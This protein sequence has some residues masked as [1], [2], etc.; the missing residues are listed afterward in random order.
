MVVASTLASLRVLVVLAL[1]SLASHRMKSLIVGGIMFFGTLLLIVGLSLLDSVETS[2]QRSLTGSITGHLQVYS[3]DARDEL[4]IF[5]SGTMGGDDIG[6]IVEFSKVKEVIEGIDGV[7]AVVPMGPVMATVVGGNDFDRALAE[8]GEALERGDEAAITAS[9]T[10][11]RKLSE[12]M[13]RGFR[14]ELEISSNTAELEAR[15]ARLESLQ[16]DAFWTAFRADPAAQ[17]RFLETKIAPLAAD[18]RM[19]ILRT[20]GT[21]LPLFGE[22]FDRFEIVEGEAVPPGERGLLINKRLHERWLKHLVARTLDRVKEARDEGRLIADDPDLQSRVALMTRQYQQILFQ[23]SPAA[24]AS[25]EAE[26]RK[27]LPQTEGDLEALVR[28]FLEVDDD[29]FEQRFAFFYAHI[30]PHIQLY[31]FNVGDTVTLRAVTKTGYFKA[32]NIKIYGRF[33]FRGL[34]GSDLSG[35]FNLMDLMT[36]RDLYGLMTDAQRA[37]LESIRQDVGVVEVSRE[38]AEDAL[39]GG[40]ADEPLVQDAVP[41]SSGFDAVDH[42]ELA[43]GTAPDPSAL[44]FTQH[45]I[46]HGLALHAAIVLDDP[47]QIDEAR[48]AI[49]AAIE[50]HGLGLT[51]VDWQAASGMVGQFVIVIRVVLYVAIVIIFLVALVIINNSMV[52]ATM[53]RIGEI[54]TLRAI[55]AQ[56]RFVLSM[57]LIETVTLGLL[58]GTLGALAASGLLV[59]LGHSGIPSGG[60]EVLIFLFSGQRLFPTLEMAHV[61]L[62]IFVIVMVSLV[63]TLYPALIA[64]RVQ[65]VVA[66]AGSGE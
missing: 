42:L 46:D 15:I 53:D 38:D 12:F 52:M 63:A 17:M 48:A 3:S 57:F 10:Q 18:G 34:E 41:G 6:E 56:R 2:M 21:D 19:I 33:S 23:L 35:A 49:E 60:N 27:L 14:N 61:A 59:W 16:D 45:D 20:I 44:R 54:G 28:A 39:F 43:L 4:A 29:N 37:E 32:V 5:G 51:V 11:L 31:P 40:G 47:E 65:P 58:A 24:Q 66:M 64:T 55:G 36:F 7:T 26:L 50:T 13:A 8:L 1:R 30:A 62:G 22:S 9:T 25:L